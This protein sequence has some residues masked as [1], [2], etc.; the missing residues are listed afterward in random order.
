VPLKILRANTEIDSNI[1]KSLELFK[2][3]KL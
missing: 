2:E 3:L 1:Q